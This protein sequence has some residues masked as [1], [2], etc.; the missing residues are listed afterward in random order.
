MLSSIIA[1][2]VVGLVVGLLGRLILP[3]RQNISLLATTAIGLVASL[4]AG[5]LLGATAYRNSN[6][7]VPWFS[8]LAGAALAAIGISL[9]G[10]LRSRA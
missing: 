2:L 9:Y 7:G 4:V 6:G 10:R 1:A 8:L 5:V 3:G